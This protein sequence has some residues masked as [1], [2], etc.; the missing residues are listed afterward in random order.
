MRVHYKNMEE[1][2]KIVREYINKNP[3]CTYNEIRENTKIKIERVYKNM[4]EAYIDAGVKLSKN[5]RKRD[6]EK[7][8]IEVINFI[9][10]NPGCSTIDIHS[11]IKV[12]V[13]RVFGCIKN[14]YKAANIK[15]P[16]KDITSGVRNP[17]VV[18]RSHD[19]EKEIID[20]LKKFGKVRPKVRLTNG[21]VDC[22]LNYDNEDF[23][24]EIKDFR[25]RNNMT[26]HEIKQLL[27][28]MD[29]LNY[30]KGILIC[31]KESFPKRKN[32]RKLYIRDKII[33]ILSG[34]D[35]RGYS[36]NLME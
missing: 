30:K 4:K 18:K 16:D 6:I 22:L 24:V 3:N 5:L 31:P 20:I 10:K 32:G 12:N 28:Y 25:G 9:K 8:K 26:M 21:I 35:L 17:E 19:F 29:A 15:Y 14:A 33:T 11:E 2:R 34:E 13:I 27:R 36:I 7:Q 1:K 23:V